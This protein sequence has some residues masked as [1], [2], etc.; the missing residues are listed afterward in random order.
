MNKILHIADL[1]FKNVHN[2]SKLLPDKNINNRFDLQL[3]LFRK[4]IDYCIKDNIKTILISGDLFDYDNPSTRERTLVYEQLSYAIDNNIYIVLIT[5][6]HDTNGYWNALSYLKFFKLNIKIV[7]TEAEIININGVNIL[8]VP[9]VKSGCECR[10]LIDKLKDDEKHIIMLHESVRGGDYGTGFKSEDGITTKDLFDLNF[11]YVALGHFHKFQMWKMDNQYIVYSG[12][13]LAKNYG[14]FNCQQKYMSILNIENNKIIPK[15]VK[16][17]VLNPLF[18]YDFENKALNSGDLKTEKLDNGIVKILHNRDADKT[19]L[20]SVYDDFMS[21]GISYIV[22]EYKAEKSANKEVKI[23]D[24]N[25]VSID[26][27]I[28]DYCKVV[29]SNIDINLVNKVINSVK[30]RSK[31]E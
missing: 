26:K 3:K 10:H 27:V 2:F 20:K 11:Q 5:G 21:K 29:N 16:L 18:I 15:F 4:I 17:P 30:E 12:S 1:H 13:L 22:F 14:D 24:I 8:A 19:A 6:N 23:D 25:I 28:E 7:D 31:S 9:F